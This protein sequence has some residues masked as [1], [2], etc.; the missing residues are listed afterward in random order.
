LGLAEVHLENDYWEAL[1]KYNAL[2]PAPV[3]LDPA[4]LAQA[5]KLRAELDGIDQASDE[6]EPSEEAERRRDEI[7]IRLDEI[8]AGQTEFTGEQKS[9]NW[10]RGC[11]YHPRFHLMGGVRR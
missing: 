2:R 9:S 11:W 7:E 10:F 5:D 6:E 1:Q 3:E 8:E 4:L